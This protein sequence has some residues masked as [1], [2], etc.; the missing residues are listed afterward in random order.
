MNHLR[1]KAASILLGGLFSIS[2]SLHAQN[3]ELP[4]TNR[5]VIEYV[6]AHMNKKIDRGECWDLLKQALDY[7][8]ADWDFPNTWGDRY[9]PQ[10]Q[11]VLPGD[12]LQYSNVVFKYRKGNVEYTSKA[13]KHSS[14][15]YEVISPTEFKVAEQNANGVRKVKLGN[16]NL[17]HKKKGKIVFYRPRK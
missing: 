17:N 1:I 10:E 6:D 14:I 16:L 15:V 8:E 12:C 2:F 5:K 7:A 4:E 11:E 3:E 13:P 9:D